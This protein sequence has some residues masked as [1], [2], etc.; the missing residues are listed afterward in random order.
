MAASK[1]KKLVYISENLI[2]KAS[3]VSRNE[4]V[5]LSKLVETALTEAIKVNELGYT[6][7]QMAQFFNVLQT[8]RVLGG[9]FVPSG[10]LDYM[11]ELCGKGDVQ[12]LQVLWYESGKWNGKY[13]KETFA[14]PVE[15]FKHFLELSRWDLNE[16][17]IKANEGLSSVKVRCV[18][19]V[20]SVEGTQLLS[21][22]IEGVLSG[23]GYRTLHLDF[24]KG[25]IIIESE[26]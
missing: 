8:N 15:A 7:K 3:R 9:L 1:G 18:S 14:D 24:L 20:M 19:T 5:S 22:Y 11:I 13:L 25:M 10:V 17:D 16:V 21:K 26:K 12:K 6:S 4:G 23:L 2:D